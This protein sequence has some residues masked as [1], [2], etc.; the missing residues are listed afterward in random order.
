MAEISASIA[1]QLNLTGPLA[2]GRAREALVI[3]RTYAPTPS[4]ATPDSLG[5]TLGGGGG[6]VLTIGQA[7]R[8]T[9][10]ALT[11]GQAVLNSLRALDASL[12]I[13]VNEG[14]V[15]PETDLRI[16][17]T[18]VSRLNITTAAGRAL[19]AIDRLVARASVAGANLIASDGGR[20]T[21]QTTEFGG[22]VTI[23]SQP[24]DSAGL[25]LQDLS[26]MT[27]AQA[28]NA[29]ARVREAITLAEGR[30]NNLG[31]LQGSLE[32]RAG[33]VNRFL[34]V[35]AEGLFEGTVRGRLVNLRA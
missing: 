1:S 7:Q 34:D 21:L 24:L 25:N 19:D 29:Q 32:T 20:I 3:E 18:R 10:A 12:G 33:T 22:R 26:A 14:L 27:L 31:A 8:L 35:G 28:R 17:E 6:A 15:S 2:V 16:N 4:R 30:L 23:R 5:L 9:S 13:A 11:Q